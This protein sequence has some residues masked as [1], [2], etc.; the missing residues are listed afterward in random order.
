LPRC[1]AGRIAIAPGIQRNEFLQKLAKF[2][3]RRDDL[4]DGELHRL[5]GAARATP[6]IAG[7]K[8]NP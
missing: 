1:S 3:G 2:V 4:G 5:C 7:Q 8:S 6:L